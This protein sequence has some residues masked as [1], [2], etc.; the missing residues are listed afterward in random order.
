MGHVGEKHRKNSGDH[1]R[2]KWGTRSVCRVRKSLADKAAALR[3]SRFGQSGKFQVYTRPIGQ[4]RRR[5]RFNRH[6]VTVKGWEKKTVLRTGLQVRKIK[7]GYDASHYQRNKQGNERRAK[8]VIGT[9][10]TVKYSVIFTLFASHT[11]LATA[12]TSR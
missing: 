6:V 8:H 10:T 3:K 12:A 5:G 11:V 4:L 2:G 7:F 9:T 1:I